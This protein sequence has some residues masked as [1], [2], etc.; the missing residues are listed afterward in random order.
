MYL[1]SDRLM[2]RQ[3]FRFR[4]Y[5]RGKPWRS[6]STG[7][8]LTIVECRFSTDEPV[9]YEGV[10]FAHEYFEY[11]PP[12]LLYPEL[13][14]QFEGR[15]F[16][17]AR[18]MSEDM[19]CRPENEV[20]GFAIEGVHGV[21]HIDLIG[22]GPTLWHPEGTDQDYLKAPILPWQALAIWQNPGRMVSIAS[23]QYGWVI[24]SEQ[25]A[26]AIPNN[27]VKPNGAFT[28]YE[29]RG[30]E[31]LELQRGKALYVVERILP[32]PDEDWDMGLQEY[33]YLDIRVRRLTDQGRFDPKG[34]TI[35]LRQSQQPR[36]AMWNSPFQ[37]V[38]LMGQMAFDGSGLSEVRPQPLIF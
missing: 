10:L 8:E 27:K 25:F 16:K 4:E 9:A 30:G 14:A 11:C 5:T 7:R 20:V 23:L 37:P 13:A 28:L 36:P 15:K 18:R 29:D 26:R 3:I 31:A 32:I 34:E 35:D 33:S 6:P 21:F 38:E 17:F 2:S 22:Y 1:K 19:W 12:F 24:R